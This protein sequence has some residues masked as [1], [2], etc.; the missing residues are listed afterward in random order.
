MFAGHAVTSPQPLPPADSADRII[1]SSD[2]GTALAQWDEE[3]NYSGGEDVCLGNLVR[4][5]LIATNVRR[6]CLPFT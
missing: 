3:K 4:K 1:F 2:I 5:N 6:D